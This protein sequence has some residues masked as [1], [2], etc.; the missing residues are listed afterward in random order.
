MALRIQA[1]AATLGDDAAA[2]F[3]SEIQGALGDMAALGVDQGIIDSIANEALDA[4]AFASDSGQALFAAMTA[5]DGATGGMNGLTSAIQRINV[6]SKT[7]PAAAAAALSWRK[8]TWT[9]I[10]VIQYSKKAM[11]HAT[12]RVLVIFYIL[13]V[14]A[15]QT[16]NHNH[17]P[18]KTR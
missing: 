13:G 14:F 17:K 11:T 2:A 16:T 12:S 10:K 3:T 4:V 1:I 8:W 6:L 5:L 18:Q 15:P 7:D 9:K